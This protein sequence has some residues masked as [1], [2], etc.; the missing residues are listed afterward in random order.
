MK[1]TTMLSLFALLATPV[2]A[3][4]EGSMG[5]DKQE[6]SISCA[7]GTTYDMETKT[8]VTATS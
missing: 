6:A 3:F 1:T 8:C 7:E 5:C 2:A 4:A